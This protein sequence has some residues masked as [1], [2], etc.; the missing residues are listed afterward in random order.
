MQVLFLKD[1]LKDKQ[2]MK[3]LFIAVFLLV[4]AFAQTG[5]TNTNSQGPS[6]QVAASQEDIKS[7]ERKIA[8]MKGEMVRAVGEASERSEK[9]KQEI[10]QKY[11]R[12][13]E[14][15]NLTL[16]KQQQEAKEREAARISQEERR[17][18]YFIG[19][20]ILLVCVT[21]GWFF[22]GNRKP[23]KTVSVA[24]V[25]EIV[26]HAFSAQSR[27]SGLVDTDILTIQQNRR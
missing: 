3:T 20:A 18:R 24:E 14:D 5:N 1:S 8:K 23:K 10:S 25:S 21:F 7:L 12:V 15:L 4:C 13:I 17:F 22:F 9:E 27:V 6:P 26:N 19:G 16:Q 2:L 11:Q